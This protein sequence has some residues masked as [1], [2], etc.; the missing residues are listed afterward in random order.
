[1]ND[2]DWME[3]ALLLAENGKITAPPN[4]WVGCVIVK[5]GIKIGSGWH[6]EPGTAHAEIHALN[7]AKENAA[8]SD[9]FITLEPCSHHGRTPP[10][11]DALIKARPRRVIVGISDPDP[12]VS[13]KGLA[14]LQKSGI[15]L[16]T[17]VLEE[18][19]KASLTPY[20]H[21]RKTGR[22]FCIAKAAISVDGKIG[23]QDGSSKWISGEE[24]RSDAHRM[25][26][27]SQAIIVGSSTFLQD[28][29]QLTA[30]GIQTSRQPMRVVLDRTGRIGDDEADWV[31]RDSSL[32]EV[33][34]ELGKRGVLQVLVEGGGKVL[35]SFLEKNL[36]D[37]L[38]L[39][40]GPCI[41][42]DQGIPLFQGLNI[43]TISQKLKLNLNK[44]I[45]LGDT[46]RLEYVMC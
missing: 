31:A 15:T 2:Q 12:N 1:M 19:I 33:L 4:P 13:G 35:G 26:G 6:I 29:P 11:V 43:E 44:N 16:V 45:T 25:R 18:K 21:H 7:Q 41:L 5:N 30:R 24:A 23:A 42:G 9:I 8:G 38:V 3:Q 37:R 46:V 20:L 14:L 10:C 36:I 34:R 22:P 40:V 39:Y 32:E 17:G 28:R 27:E